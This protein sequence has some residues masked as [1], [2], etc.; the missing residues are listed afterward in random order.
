MPG[1]VLISPSILSADQTRLADAIIAA[2]EGGADM[3]HVDIMDGHFVDNITIGPGVVA[4]IAKVAKEVDIP[5]D[6]HLMI[7]NPVYHLDKFI[8]A[9]PDYL[10]FHLEAT[11]HHHMGLLK[12]KNA[13]IKAGI[14]IN[15]STPLYGLEE[16]IEMMDL[17][18]IMTVNPGWGGQKYIELVEDKIALAR[19]FVNAENQ[20]C[21]IM[22]DGGVDPSNSARLIELGVDI[23]VAGN[24]VFKGDGTI[25]ENIKALRG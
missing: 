7:E 15:P 2:K 22:V 9:K 11:V 3:I 19:D 4:D 10:A 16:I 23:L 8:K 21:R 1:K 24:W 17:L 12:I 14:A 20:E 6:V 5:L 13:G 25:A 18:I